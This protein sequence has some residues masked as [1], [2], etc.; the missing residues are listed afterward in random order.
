MDWKREVELLDIKSLKRCI[1]QM[2]WM[3]GSHLDHKL[4]KCKKDIFMT[5]GEMGL[6]TVLDNIKNYVLVRCANS[7]VFM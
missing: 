6:L 7:I 5:V 2:Q 1:N 3:S 4:N